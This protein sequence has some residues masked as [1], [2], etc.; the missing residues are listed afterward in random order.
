MQL[1]QLPL[2]QKLET[3]QNILIAGAGGGFDIYSGLPLYWHLKAQGV[4]LAN[5]SF[6]WLED[7]TAF[8][9]HPH[10][11]LITSN[12]INPIRAHYFPEKY[13]CQFLSKQKGIDEKI[14]G[15][16]RVG[17]KP[18]REAYNYLVDKLNIDTII[19][20]DG[21]TDS[22][23]FGN[24]EGLG[25]PVEDIASMKAA[26]ESTAA[27]KFLVC[28]GFGVDHYHNVSH[29]RFLENVAAL[30]KIGGYLGSLQLL[31]EMEAVQY[32]SGAVEY[33]NKEM[34][35]Y[36]SIVANSV[37]SKGKRTNTRDQ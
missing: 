6:V 28:L 31:K 4:H 12:S 2:F 35:I 18:L 33:A 11:Y 9:L 29:Y 16:D 37:V 24:E 19:L 34:G 25:T 5:L 26:F 36:S 30:S 1:N 7:T 13:L 23:M 14:Y 21:G 3:A 22:L 32:F 15:F 17:A 10:C 8:A 20:V 27:Q